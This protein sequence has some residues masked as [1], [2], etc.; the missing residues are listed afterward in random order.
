MFNFL[1][2]IPPINRLAKMKKN[3]YEL[4]IQRIIHTKSTK[5]FFY[6]K[7]MFFIRYDL[8]LIKIKFFRGEIP[9]C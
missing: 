6:N 3:Y 4:Y 1:G 7:E 8:S 5:I 9:C 2:Q